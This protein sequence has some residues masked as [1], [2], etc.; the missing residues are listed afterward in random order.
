[1]VRELVVSATSGLTVYALGRVLNGANIG[2]WG[3]VIQN[4]FDIYKAADLDRY[5]I[6]MTELGASGFYQADM[7]SVFDAESAVEIIFYDQAG[8]SPAE[9]D[10]K[11]SGSLYEFIDDWVSTQDL[12]V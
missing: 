9:S 5:D 3:N 7:P 11:L 10:T 1:M 12:T 6:E 8:V 2:R 4:T